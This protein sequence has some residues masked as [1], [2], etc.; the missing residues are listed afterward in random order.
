MQCVRSSFATSQDNEVLTEAEPEAVEDSGEVVTAS[1]IYASTG[2][3]G[4]GLPI[5]SVESG[6]KQS[7]EQ[8]E[9]LG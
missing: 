1:F 9:R 2:S 3:G 6:K 8:G 7:A 5:V 4:H